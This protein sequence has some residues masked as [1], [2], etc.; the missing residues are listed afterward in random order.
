[1]KTIILSSV[2]SLGAILA[3]GCSKKAGSAESCEDVY[4]H[5]LSLMPDEIKSMVE[6]DK[7]KAIAK[8]EKMSIESR[9]CALDATSMEDLMKCS[10]K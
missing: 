4:N 2:I 10:K 6:K 9:Q 1:M 3:V 8:C 7:P 5:T